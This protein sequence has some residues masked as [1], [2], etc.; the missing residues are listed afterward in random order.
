MLPINDPD[1]VAEVTA[2]HEEYEA[3]L[4]ANDVETLT[5]L[6]WNSPHALRFGVA[7]SLYG[8]EE[9][10]AF[11]K[12]RSPIG[13]DRKVFNAKVV[14][15]HSY[16]AAVTLEFLRPG[17]HHGRQSQM[18]WKFPEGWKI[19]SA[20]VSFSFEN[21]AKQ[22]AELVSLPIPPENMNGVVQNV[23]RAKGIAAPMLD[24][25][26]TDQIQSAP[27]FEP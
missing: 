5:R 1:V 16:C 11:R 22:A 14:V 23:M 3:A 13:L 26:L 6:F 20:H 7:E 24:F 10:E 18:W 17:G 4:E 2:L 27:R 15:F 12:S 21:Y 19:V 8:A 25:R 9:I